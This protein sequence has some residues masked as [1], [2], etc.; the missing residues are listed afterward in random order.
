MPILE[1]S[2]TEQEALALRVDLLR[3][4]QQRDADVGLSVLAMADAMAIGAAQLDAAAGRPSSL[5]DRLDEVCRRIETTYAVAYR[6]MS[7]RRA[8][9]R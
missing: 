5:Q 6:D 9:R 8:N 4:L 3:F 1:A 2:V 7:V